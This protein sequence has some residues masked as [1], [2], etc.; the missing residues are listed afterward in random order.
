MEAGARLWRAVY[1]SCGFAL[2]EVSG[3]V[4]VGKSYSD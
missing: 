4:A 3:G 2:S 1:T